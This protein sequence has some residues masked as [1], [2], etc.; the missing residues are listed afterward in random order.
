MLLTSGTHHVATV[1]ADI[2]RLI[3]FYERV[4]DA[5]ATADRSEEGLRHVFLDLGSDF[6]GSSR[7]DLPRRGARPRRALGL[8]VHPV[9]RPCLRFRAR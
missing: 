1:T 5:T 8:E 4:F 2:D 3:G 6:L 7:A 9:A